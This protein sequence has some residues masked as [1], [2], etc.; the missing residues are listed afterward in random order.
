M[1]NKTLSDSE[2]E[3]LSLGLSF[4]LPKRNI[5]FTDH[6][7]AFEILIN[8]FKILQCK[9]K[10]WGG[11]VKDI[12]SVAHSSLQDFNIFKQS[13]P[14]LP[15]TLYDSLIKL[16]SDKFIIITRPDKGRGTVVIKKDDYINKLKHIL[17][18]TSKFTVI[19]DNPFHYIT[20]LED[21]LARLLRQLL[22]LNVIT[23]NIFNHLFTSGSLPGIP[24]G[25]PKT[26]K[27]GNPVRPI[28]STLNTF[29]I[30]H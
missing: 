9:P 21:Q 23:K 1:S 13:F 8:N 16:K 24:Y 29:N 5:K 12:A 6:F 20:N 3:V 26:H 22:K 11:M 27:L 18:D 4:A 7:L 2:L 10:D 30:Q 17:S 14:K 15:Q 28:P 19:T 25:I